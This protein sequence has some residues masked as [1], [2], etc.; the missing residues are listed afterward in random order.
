MEKENMVRCP[1]DLKLTIKKD[2]GEFLI[3][4]ECCTAVSI[5]LKNSG[6]LATSFFGAHNPEVV[7]I[8][9]K[10]I[11]MYFKAIKKTLKEEDKWHGE[12]IPK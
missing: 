8:M 7:E 11:K 5:I 3:D 1:N 2:N 12:E 10:S 6:E 4:E 9:E